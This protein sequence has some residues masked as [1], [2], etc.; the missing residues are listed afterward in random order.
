MLIQQQKLDAFLNRSR[1]TL[2]LEG[3]LKRP[4]LDTLRRLVARGV[5]VENA[6][7]GVPLWLPLGEDS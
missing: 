4:R 5:A 2:L 3:A 6:T 7:D 1:T